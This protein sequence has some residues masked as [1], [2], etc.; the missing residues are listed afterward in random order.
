MIFEDLNEYNGAH[1]TYSVCNE[2][3]SIWRKALEGISV[4]NAAGICS[5]GEISLFNILP[6][7]KKQLQLIDH[8]YTS[9]YYAIGK[10]YAIKKLGAEEAYK[11]FQSP[12]LKELKILF[13]EANKNLPTSKFNADYVYGFSST[14]LQRAFKDLSITDLEGLIEN[15]GKLKFLHGDLSDLVDR[16]PFDLVY[17]SNALEYAGRTHNKNYPIQEIVK[18]GGLIC[19]THGAYTGMPGLVS[20][21]EVLFQ[22]EHRSSLR[23]NYVVTKAPE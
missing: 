11:A 15:E 6:I 9:M 22:E 20:K 5:G 14:S 13:Q 12:V 7:V 23:W 17:L 8:C 18:P 3:T 21:F 10:L 19:L 16:G 2:S 4:E 1:T